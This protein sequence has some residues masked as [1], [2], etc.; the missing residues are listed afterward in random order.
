[1][2]VKYDLKNKYIEI[3]MV[4]LHFSISRR[5]YRSDDLLEMSGFWCASFISIIFQA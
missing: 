4:N 2:I 5:N 3:S 1:M